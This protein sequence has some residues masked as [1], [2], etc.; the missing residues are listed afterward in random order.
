MQFMQIFYQNAKNY[1]SLNRRLL[2]HQL[3]LDCKII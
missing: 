1:V 3:V 2:P